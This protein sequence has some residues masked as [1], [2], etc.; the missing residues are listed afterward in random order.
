METQSEEM[1][2]R[3]KGSMALKGLSDDPVFNS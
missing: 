1:K 3:P 2:M